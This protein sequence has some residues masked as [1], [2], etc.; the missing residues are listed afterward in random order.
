MQTSRRPRPNRPALYDDPTMPAHLGDVRTV[1]YSLGPPDEVDLSVQG[2]SENTQDGTGLYRREVDRAEFAMATQ[3]GDS[4]TLEQATSLLAPEVAEL[5]FTYY[6]STTTS[7]TW[8]SNLQGYMPSAVRVTIAIRRPPP[9]AARLGLAAADSGPLIIY[10]TLVDLPNSQIKPS[11]AGSQGSSGGSGSTGGGS[12][13]TGGSSGS[14]GGSS[15]STGGGSGSTGGGSGNTGGGSGNTG[16][17][18]GNTGGSKGS[19]GSSKGS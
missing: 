14:T 10:D 13:N 4:S 15:G 12:G 16:G 5:T 8:D 18:K 3:N 2:V 9:K 1:T 19:A 11:Q 7:D 17:S 6:D